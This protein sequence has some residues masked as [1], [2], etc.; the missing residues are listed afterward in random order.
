MSKVDLLKELGRV[1]Q[2]IDKM[3]LDGKKYSAYKPLAQRHQ[4]IVKLLE[5]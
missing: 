4:L 2:A 5:Q 1:N 3:I